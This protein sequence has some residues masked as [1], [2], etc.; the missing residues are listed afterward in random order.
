[1]LDLMLGIIMKIVTILLD[2]AFLSVMFPKE[3]KSGKLQYAWI[4]LGSIFIMVS[5]TLLISMTMLK[6]FLMFVSLAITMKY[7]LGLSF[8]ESIIG[9]AIFEAISVCS[10]LIA[11]LLVRITVG[12]PRF[13]NLTN[14]NWAFVMEILSYVVVLIIII[15]ISAIRGKTNLSRMDIKGWIVF[16]LFPLF[17]LYAVVSFVYEADAATSIDVIARYIY[18]GI[19]M[20]LLN[21]SLLYLLNNVIT[22]ELEMARQKQLVENANHVYQLYESLSEENEARK[23]QAHDYLNHLNTMYILAVNG[24]YEKQKSYISQQINATTTDSD[25]FDTGNKIINAV[26]NRK[27]Q[28]AT[29]KGIVFPIVSDNLSGVSIKDS[30]LVTILSNVIDNAIEASEKTSAGKITL[31]IRV[32]EGKLYISCINTCVPNESGTTNLKTTKADSNNHGYGLLNIKRAVTNN[33]G[34]LT[35]DKTENEFRI[36]IVI[37]L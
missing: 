35:V 16:S 10:E 1:M 27:Y 25:M 26:I 2:V 9:N 30:D 6:L 34:Q 28:E 36:V 21:I 22:R 5:S 4:I 37:P 11:L 29:S 18:L 24:D 32:E 17:T 3:N 23:S 31:K 13:I 7:F 8:K 19:G 20:L 12:A 33:G 15:A 14:S